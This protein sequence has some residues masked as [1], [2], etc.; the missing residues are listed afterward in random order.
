MRALDES[1]AWNDSKCLLSGSVQER[2]K[3][4]Q[5]VSVCPRLFA[6]QYF[7]LRKHNS[8]TLTLF[9]LRTRILTHEHNPPLF[10][11][12]NFC[13]NIAKNKYSRLNPLLIQVICGFL[14]KATYFRVATNRTHIKGMKDGFTWLSTGLSGERLGIQHE[15]SGYIKDGQFLY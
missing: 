13:V 8:K 11:I 12:S 14:I 5:A 15:T 1:H 7:G 3:L 4:K 6:S 2:S 10:K 9:T